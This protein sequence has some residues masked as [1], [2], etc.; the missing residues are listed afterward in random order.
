MS[1][2][3][4]PVRIYLGGAGGAPTNNVITSL[5]G[6]GD[7]YLIGGSSSPT[8]L[9]LADVDEKHLVPLATAQNYKKNLLDLF[10]RTHPD[11]AHFQNDFEVRAVSR[12]R[13]DVIDRGVK[14]YMPTAQV[15]E[16]C[17]DKHRSYEIWRA[18]GVRTPE[19]LLITDEAAL[20]AAF[21]Q[22]G[23]ELWLRAI[24]GG[25]GR[26]ALPTKDPLFAKIWIERFNGWGEFTA[27]QL[28]GERTVTWLAIFHEGELVVAQ[29]RRRRSWGF[30]NR[31][32]S[33][34]TGVTE[35]GETWSD[36]EVTRLA[37][38]AISSIDSRPHG[39]YGVDMTYGR[40]GLPY[41]TEINISRFFTTVA[42]FTAAGLN[43][44]RI[45]VDI[46]LK[47]E[48]PTL[49]KRI[50][51]LP[52]GLLWIRGMDR[53]PALVKAQEVDAFVGQ[54]DLG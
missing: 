30:G 18:A 16:D 5:R 36:E 17:V 40:D 27:A 4:S 3:N 43:M 33:G 52:D 54:A 37:Q 35:V 10:D 32:L 22:F 12:F 19:T 26:G 1:I 53:S 51:P 21:E 28:L 46:A 7:E 44:P 13:Q 38:D 14:L 41:V 2:E 50:N 23:G 42:F 45:L 20:D 6:S 34:V 49:D 47:D 9:Y 48:F 8:D 24:E 15:I 39:I 31:T 11:L 29:T 25:G